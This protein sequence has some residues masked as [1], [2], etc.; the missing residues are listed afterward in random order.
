MKRTLSIVLACGLLAASGG[1]YAAVA[2]E[3]VPDYALKCTVEYKREP[4]ADENIY[5]GLSINGY[6]YYNMRFA[7]GDVI[8]YEVYLEDKI[9]GL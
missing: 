1:G 8:E 3:S 6:D 7:S 9:P 5:G 2:E 4:T